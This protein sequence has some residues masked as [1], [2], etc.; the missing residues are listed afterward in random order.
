M[1]GIRPESSQISLTGTCEQDIIFFGYEPLG[2]D[3]YPAFD[4][5]NP[6]RG[7][8]DSRAGIYLRTVPR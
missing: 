1:T 3:A 5:G 7:R 2:A 6:D 4:P 8:G